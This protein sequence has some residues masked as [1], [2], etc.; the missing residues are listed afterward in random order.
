LFPTD[1][2]VQAVRFQGAEDDIE[3]FYRH[4]KDAAGQE[5]V[6][7]QKYDH[8]CGK[9][10]KLQASDL[11]PVKRRPCWH[12]MRDLCIALDGTVLYC[13]ED[14]DGLKE[15]GERPN[16]FNCSS[17]GEIWW[18]ADTEQVSGGLYNKHT[19][20]I[21]PGQCADCDEYYTFNF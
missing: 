7:I 3:A 13:R 4:W 20:G 17:I 12:I 6:I 16:V 8:F 18:A 21:Y 5:Q 11:S 15:P 1:T 14:L 9:L 10:P 19:A 2:Y